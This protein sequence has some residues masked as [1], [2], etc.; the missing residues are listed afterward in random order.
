VT[1]HPEID[2]FQQ[3]NYSGHLGTNIITSNLD[4]RT[5]IS[6]GLLVEDIYGTGD[7]AIK[8]RHLIIEHQV[9]VLP[10]I[11]Y[12]DDRTNDPLYPT[13]GDLLSA[14]AEVGIPT[15]LG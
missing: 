13:A 15:K 11:G 8:A 14:S 1:G 4:N 2:T 10:S 9:N 6:P 5:S 3:T 7:S 12:Q